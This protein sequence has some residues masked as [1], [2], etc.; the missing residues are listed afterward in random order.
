MS[1]QIQNISKYYGANLVLDAVSLDIE[2][3]EFIALLGPSGSGKTTLP[4][5]HCRST[6]CRRGHTVL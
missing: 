1:L 5:H 6:I 4:A 3:G 2:P